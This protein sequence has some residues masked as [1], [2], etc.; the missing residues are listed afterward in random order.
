MSLL[1]LIMKRPIRLWGKKRGDRMTG[2]WLMGRVGEAAFFGA[3]TLLGVTTLS[4][5]VGWQLISPE[6]NAYTVG[7][8]FWLLILVSVT[9]IGIGSLGFGYHVLAV[10]I[11]DERRASLARGDAAD[12]SH[13]SRPMRPVASYLPSL[14]RYTDS[15]GVHLNF[16]LPELHPHTNR[17]L[18]I[19]IF[20]LL[21][22]A[23]VVVMVTTLIGRFILGQPH[24]FATL[25]VGFFGFVAFRI[26]RR[27]LV[28]FF[29]ATRIGSTAVE[30]ASLPLYPGQATHMLIVQHGRMSLRKLRVALVCE[31]QATYHFGTDVR[32]EA[33][34]IQRIIMLDKTRVRI[35]DGS[36]LRLDCAL[37][38]PATAMH[39]FASPHNAIAW[40]VIVEGEVSRWPSFYRSF[41]VVVYPPVPP[42]KAPALS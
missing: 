30:V 33:F 22:D 37:Q 12:G 3:L 31:E 7:Y 20:V 5:V 40:K 17:L 39:S 36:P 14:L 16:R 27:F 4:I 19:A 42:A 11:S 28:E 26:S 2:W 13:S 25:V 29:Y 23:F 9:F 18:I 21:W 41:P 10:A 24:W 15:P 38:L 32:T 1:D 34:E 6:T 35:Q 8:G